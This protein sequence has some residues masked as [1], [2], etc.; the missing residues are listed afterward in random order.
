MPAA[1]AERLDQAVAAA[2]AERLE[3]AVAARIATALDESV[4]VAVAERLA[5][6][7]AAAREEA[8]KEGEEAS[9]DLLICLGQVRT[10]ACPGSSYLQKTPHSI[11]SRCE[12]KSTQPD[13]CLVDM[14]QTEPRI[15]AL[16]ISSA[17]DW[18]PRDGQTDLSTV[19]H[20][21]TVD[22]RECTSECF[23]QD[24]GHSQ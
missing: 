12:G 13:V 3:Q 2:V 5:T 22:Q 16:V 21:E 14:S 9:V 8:E 1:V 17:P 11:C 15:A 10:I 24:H 6:A 23:C 18:K 19:C 4:E 7:C 20:L